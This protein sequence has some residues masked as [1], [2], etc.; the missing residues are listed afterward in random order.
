MADLKTAQEGA[1]GVSGVAAHTRR[2]VRSAL[3]PSAMLSPIAG[4]GGRRQ[5]QRSPPS[6]DEALARCSIGGT[7]RGSLTHRRIAPPLDSQ[8]QD[9]RSRSLTTIFRSQRAVDKKAKDAQRKK[10]E[11]L[12]KQLELRR[13]EALARAAAAPKDDLEQEFRDGM[14]VNPRPAVALTVPKRPAP[15]SDDERKTRDEHDRECTAQITKNLP[16]YMEI[17]SHVSL[18]SEMGNEELEEAARGASSA[19]LASPWCP[20]LGLRGGRVAVGGVGGGWLQKATQGRREELRRLGQPAPPPR[21][22]RARSS[23]AARSARGRQLQSWRAGL[24]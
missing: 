1:V 16:K 24:R 20:R 9:K 14:M 17:L 10:D 8:K 2:A 6:P 5:R 18:F 13:K 23:H 11:A 19:A 15:M 4:Q 12:A 22:T 21:L 3:R 7:C